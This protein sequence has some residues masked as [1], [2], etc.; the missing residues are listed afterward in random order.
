MPPQ[1]LLL[2]VFCTI[3][4]L[5]RA[6]DWPRLRARGPTPA[7]ADS[8]V[9]AIEVAGE[10]RGLADDTAIFRH[11][12]RYH[13]AEFPALAR[14][15]RTRFARQAAD[16]CWLARRVHRALADRLSR[17]GA[18]W[19]VDSLPL[20]VCRFARSGICRRF[21]GQAGFGHDPVAGKIFYGFR[22]HLRT[23][24]DGV[25]LGYELAPGPAH[26]L[27]IARE[28]APRP[29]G[30][31]LGDRNYWSPA[32]RAEFQAAGGDLVAP[33]KQAKFDPTP[34]RTEVL[35]AI[36]RRIETTIGQ[37][38]DRLNCRRVKV[39][40]LWHLE[41][42]LVRKILGHTLGAWLNILAG[43]QPLKLECLVA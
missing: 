34:G 29:V 41:H 36:R 27:D 8:E 10:I 15:T 26:E 30:T 22:L 33:F 6:L 43:E 25:I 19:L 20:P 5:V 17:P 23:G 7:L 24:L 11:F 37:L 9:I 12:R 14:I 21:G 40:D 13:L 4:D 2:V 18:P 38:V 16:T 28:L 32:T 39:R 35:M 42:R 31:A 1:E 3:D